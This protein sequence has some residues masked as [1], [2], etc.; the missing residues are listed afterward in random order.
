MALPV[1]IKVFPQRS[2]ISEPG[3][4]QSL[5]VMAEYSDGSS[6][7]VTDQAVFLSNN[8]AAATVARDNVVKATGPGDAFILARFDQFTSG[9]SFVV[10]SG[11]AYP[12]MDFEPRNYVDELTSA[13]WR[14]L[15]V[16]P[17][18]V[19]SDEVFLRRVYLDL[20]G[21]LPTPDQRDWPFSMTAILPN[22][23]LLSTIWST[24]KTF[25]ICG[26]CNSLS[27][28]RFDAPMG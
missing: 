4:S 21:L 28:C 13:R 26:S 2:V 11:S 3:Q 19:A 16:L 7:D 22:A 15:H 20:T 5:I 9:T 23:M 1:G 18:P 6:R 27:S 14:D 10:R 25:L 17:S 24:R 8:D 12:E